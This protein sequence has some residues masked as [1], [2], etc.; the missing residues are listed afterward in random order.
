MEGAY[1]MLKCTLYWVII[2]HTLTFA[3]ATATAGCSPTVVS[4]RVL[5][6][7]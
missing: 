1:S 3:L 6:A 4:N 5:F 7:I 2:A